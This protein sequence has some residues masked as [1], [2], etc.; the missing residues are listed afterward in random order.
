MSSVTQ[1]PGPGQRAGRRHSP[2]GDRRCVGA[3][4]GA[5]QGW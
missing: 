3:A 4:L 5:R 1:P 2:G